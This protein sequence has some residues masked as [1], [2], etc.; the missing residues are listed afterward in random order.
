VVGKEV[1]ISGLEIATQ[2][3]PNRL[4][5]LTRLGD[6]SIPVTRGVHA[7]NPFGEFRELNWSYD[8]G[9][10][11]YAAVE[12]VEGYYVFPP[13]FTAGPRR[14]R[15]GPP[16]GSTVKYTSRAF[17]QNPLHDYESAWWIAVWFVFHCKPEGVADSVMKKARRDVDRN[18]SSTFVLGTIERSCDLLP[19]VLQP[20]GGVLVEM[21]DILVRAYRSFEKSFDDS[22]MLSVFEEL[23]PCLQ[24][25]V[26]LA[27]GLA[28]APP[29]LRW[30]L[31]IE[32][33]E[34][35]AVA[36][37]RERGQQGQQ[38]IEQEGGAEGQ[39]MAVDDP[40]VGA[41]TGDLVL[42]FEEASG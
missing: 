26:E 23:K 42:G 3:A 22:K 20:L 24:N 4:E 5:E 8:Q 6:P 10:L 2:W 14:G 9:T 31:D 40:S 15:L 19:P 13:E 12:V 41:E 30:K 29:A 21:R 17:V 16:T 11:Y 32:E 7:V 33:L 39:P 25:L 35:D 28:A 38:A 1:K 37:E 36:L 27:Q 34:F 18:H